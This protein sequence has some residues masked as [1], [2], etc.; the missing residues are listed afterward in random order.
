VRVFKTTYK[1]KHGRTQEAAKWYVE[2]RD[3]LD[4][5]R[6]LP[7]FTSKAA[8]EELGRNLEKLVAFH[9]ASGGQTDPALTRFLVGL[10]ARTIDKLVRIGLLA[11][12]RVATAKPLSE[13]LD[14]FAAALAAK[15][16][17]KRH[18]ELVTARAR[19]LLVVAC[20]F[21][22]LG[23]IAA[24]KV[25]ERLHDMRA[26]AADGRCTSGISAQTHNFYLQ[27][28]KQFCRWAVKD[29]R[30]LE[31]PLGHLD[32]L[33]V[34]TDR[35][36]DRR[37]LTVDELV[38]L[39]DAA[40]SGP[41]RFGM[42]GGERAML[43][44]LAVETGLRA[45][46]LR[47]LTRSSFH[48][49][50]D[51][52]SVT[53]AAEYSKRRREDALPLRPALAQELVPFLATKMPGAQV[54]KVPTFG[55]C[56]EMFRFDLKAA[57]IGYRD[58]AGLVADFHALRHTFIS[59]LARGGV[60]PKVAQALARHSTITLTMDRYSHTVLSEQSA[61]LDALP[62]LSAASRKAMRAT[63]TDD[64]K[65]ADSDLAS[66]LALSERF[67]STS[68]DSGGQS[69]DNATVN[70][71]LEKTGK[72]AVFPMNSGLGSV[73][74]SGDGLGLQNRRGA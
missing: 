49:D 69:N 32:G 26:S 1:D 9:K 44:R 62:D 2:F 5:I 36:H 8:S 50:G 13:H 16:N 6:R 20:G 55:D 11:P 48:L 51:G 22:Y 54:F 72:T 43:Y 33:N 24:G 23:D 41:V 74:T 57:G 37:A 40:S 18:F 29:R 52:P 25:M 46:E 61:A 4:Y 28:V 70:Q 17:S 63:G 27:A 53:V 34:K 68:V 42:A 66:C 3:A 14:D 12:T 19:R 45:G 71:T 39:L 59:N 58:D 15:G 67:P 56:A 10:P 35:R 65:P 31:N 30:A 73:S 60:H 21:K 38:R 7:A 47:S 64:A